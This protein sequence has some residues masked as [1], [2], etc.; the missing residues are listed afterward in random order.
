[1]ICD[2]KRVGWGFHK[3]SLEPAPFVHCLIFDIL[4][5]GI[6]S[7]QKQYEDTRLK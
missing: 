3:V 2:A 4:K 1:M 6:S 5:S 7:E